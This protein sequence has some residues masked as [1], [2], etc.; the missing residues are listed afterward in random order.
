MSD[1]QPIWTLGLKLVTS[2]SCVHGPHVSVERHG[3]PFAEWGTSELW[4]GT[5]EQK[6]EREVKNLHCKI[7]SK[8]RTKISKK[9]SSLLQF[10]FQACVKKCNNIHQ[11]HQSNA[12][13]IKKLRLIK[14]IY[15]LIVGGDLN[16]DWFP[17]SFPLLLP[18]SSL[19]RAPLS[20]LSPLSG[21]LYILL[22]INV[23]SP[24]DCGELTKNKNNVPWPG[25]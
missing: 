16:C 6:G 24:M 9:G 19:S 20:G 15:I 13:P 12:G 21:S 1:R 7:W 17:C 18:F 4:Q 8:H 11:L 23:R 2:W 14:I 10:Q 3:S 25:K 22:F 5:S